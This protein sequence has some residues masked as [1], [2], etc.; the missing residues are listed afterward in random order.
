MWT[1]ADPARTRGVG[2]RAA[3]GGECGPWAL[4]ALPQ[5]EGE[6]LPVHP[7]ERC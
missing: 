4:A 6:G 7:R 5:E 3:Q 1:V 2:P